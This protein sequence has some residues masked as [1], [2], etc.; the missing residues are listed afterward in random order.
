MIGGWFTRTPQN[1]V[2]L[3]SFADN[4]PRR[5]LKGRGECS[6]SSR[7]SWSSSLTQR[8]EAGEERKLI[9]LKLGLGRAT[10]R[11]ADPA[12]DADTCEIAEGAQRGSKNWMREKRG[13]PH[14]LSERSGALG[15]VARSK[16]SS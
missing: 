3:H 11:V 16:R 9:F 13:D 8:R 2:A 4:R 10:T 7:G 14:D 1:D 15:R 12:V 5:R 6:L